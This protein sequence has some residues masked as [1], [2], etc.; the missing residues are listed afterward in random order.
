MLINVNS[1]PIFVILN[2]IILTFVLKDYSVGQIYHA[3]IS[4]RACGILFLI[5]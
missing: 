2:R 1:I 4:G 5:M 3:N